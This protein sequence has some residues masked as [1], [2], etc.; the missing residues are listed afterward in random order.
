MIQLKLRRKGAAPGAYDV[1]GVP[2]VTHRREF[3][4]EPIF[5]FVISD[6]DECCYLS[7]EFFRQDLKEWRA[8][9]QKFD[10]AEDI[11]GL[12]LARAEIISRLE[13]EGYECEFVP[14]IEASG[15]YS[16]LDL[17]RFPYLTTDIQEA[18]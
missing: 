8:V 15:P 17:A 1:L 12:E 10:T 9:T 4:L 14:G 16:E 2:E 3:P 5:K 18:G 7:T 11:T 6:G 13:A